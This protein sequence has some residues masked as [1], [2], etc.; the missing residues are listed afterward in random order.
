MEQISSQRE[1]DRLSICCPLILLVCCE[2]L[3]Y[4][5]LCCSADLFFYPVSSMMQPS[6]A[7]GHLQSPAKVRQKQKHGVQPVQPQ[8]KRVLTNEEEKRFLRVDTW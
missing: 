5:S 8:E 4:A 3:L 6:Q 1:H 7:S 2:F